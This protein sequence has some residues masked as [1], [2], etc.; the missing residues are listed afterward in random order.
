MT[1]PVRS[2]ASTSTRSAISAGRVNRPVTAPAAA[3]A[4]TAAG[5]SPPAWATVCA[6]PWSPSQRP[7][8]TGPGLIVFTR[9][10]AGPTSFDND[11]QKFV[12]A[13]LAAE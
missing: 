3:W 2:L 12:S 5:S 7:V 10:P 4:A 11:L 13:A 9:M 8:S 6:T 1:L